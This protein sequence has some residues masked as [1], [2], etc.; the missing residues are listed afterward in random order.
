MGLFVFA[1]IVIK[2]AL[3]QLGYNNPVVIFFCAVRAETTSPDDL[4][5]Y[6]FC[7]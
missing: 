5:M 6:S 7:A 1:G 4:I 3:V 2:C